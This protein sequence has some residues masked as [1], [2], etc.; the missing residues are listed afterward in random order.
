MDL[1][2][3]D[4]DNTIIKNWFEPYHYAT[5]EQLEKVF[6]KEQQY[7]YNICRKRLYEMR[8][9]EFINVYKDIALNKNIYTYNNKKI[10]PPTYH[11]LK[12]LDVLAEMIYL[13]FNIEYFD[14]DVSWMNNTVLSD[15]FIIFTVNNRRYH[16]FIEL[17]FSNNSHNLEKYDRLYSSGEV[18]KFL[19][20]SFFPRILFVTDRQFTNLNVHK[21]D[22]ITI[23]TKL[24][25]LAS[26]LI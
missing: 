13:G 21:T 17:Q 25:G 24:K 3:T 19:N 20:K 4:R 8:K 14:H 10:K 15:G 23:D 22:V 11:M 1:M 12:L 16:F 9:A 2:I 6:F 5:I 7:S 18:Q 26:I